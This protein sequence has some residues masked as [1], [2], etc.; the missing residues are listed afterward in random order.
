VSA[1]DKLHNAR[2]IV[3]DL[4]IHGEALWPRFSGGRESLWY[5]RSLVNA[6]RPQGNS[7]LIDELGRVVTEMENLSGVHD[8]R[9]AG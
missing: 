1:A 4:R 5:Y 8:E 2:A 3:R 9:D 7:D 6:L